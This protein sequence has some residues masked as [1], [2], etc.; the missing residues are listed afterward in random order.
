MDWSL[1]LAS[2]GIEPIIEHEETD[3]GWA[4]VV[5]SQDHQRAINAIGM[6]RVENRGW[7][8]QRHVFRTRL[9]FD[10]AGLAWVG[11]VILFFALDGTGGL[12]AV[13]LME[14]ARIWHG[15]WWRLFTGMWLHADAAHL[16]A[17]TTL[18][19]LLLGLA[20]G[21]FGTGA[22]LLAA[23]LAGAGGN[24]IACLV[25][26]DR[27]PGLGASGMVM[28]SLGLLAVQSLSLLRRTPHAPKYI[29]GGLFGGLMLFVL[30]GL[31]PGT[32]VVAH[33]GG[34]VSGLLLGTV[35]TL[36]PRL[37]RS[38]VSNLL[39]GGLF[40]VLVIVPWWLALRS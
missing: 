3:G 34:F 11:L 24:I 6:Y 27:G 33:L 23:Y 13:G 18:G 28:G 10:W 4:L 29:F 17:N 20:M 21:R 22:G 2:Q 16:A 14:P 5:P 19:L 12:R 36:W 30:F 15:Q 39:S 8:W 7:P 31:S 38:T 25:S 9:V 1:V 37:A 40:S 32:D 35:L 26:P